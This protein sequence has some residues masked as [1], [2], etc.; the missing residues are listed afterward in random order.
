MRV[1][2]KI[3]TVQNRLRREK[4]PIVKKFLYLP[5]TQMLVKY[6]IFSQISKVS[7]VETIDNPFND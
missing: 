1:Q 5:N 4:K 7:L 3:T 2:N 6:R